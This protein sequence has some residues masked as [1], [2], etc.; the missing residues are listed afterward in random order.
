[1]GGIRSIKVGDVVQYI[2]RRFKFRNG[3]LTA[4]VKSIKGKIVTYT[5]VPTVSNIASIEL[6]NTRPLNGF[7]VGDKLKVLEQYGIGSGWHSV[8][9]VVTALEVSSDGLIEGLEESPK[10]GGGF[11]FNNSCYELTDQDSYDMSKI[12]GKSL[13]DIL[14]KGE[15][16]MTKLIETLV[17]VDGR[18]ADG[19]SDDEVFALISAREQSI[20]T[21]NKIKNKP[22]TLIRKL[23]EM[24][25]EVSD[26]VDYIDRRNKLIISAINPDL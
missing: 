24:A 17:Y 14:T 23:V 7:V 5:D 10:G 11:Q 2:R 8:G 12:N 9:S 19:V 21:L 13:V 22:I 20:D 25:N 3:G 15:E 16:I 4:T 26:L 1:M 18:K 6:E